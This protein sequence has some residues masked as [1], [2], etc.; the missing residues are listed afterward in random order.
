MKTGSGLACSDQEI[1]KFRILKR[2]N[3]GKC[4][5]IILD[6]LRRDL[7][8]FR[9]LLGENPW[10][11]ILR[12]GP[13]EL[14]DFQVWGWPPPNSK[15]I[16]LYTQA[17]KNRWQE[18]CMS[19][20]LPTKLRQKKEYQRWKQEQVTQWESSNTVQACRD[21]IRIAKAHLESNLLRNITGK[22]G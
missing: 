16:S 11:T 10:E 2:G 9:D 18:A 3:M 13:R 8:L 20:M 6:F 21:R 1:V 12:S 22:K 19:K 5:I 4:R 15:I 17:V 7:G 14:V